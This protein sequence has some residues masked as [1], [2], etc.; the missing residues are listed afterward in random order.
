MERQDELQEEINQL[1]NRL[2]TEHP[3]LYRFIIES[4]ATI[5]NN[6]DKNSH[7]FVKSLEKYR[8]QLIEILKTTK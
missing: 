8:N 6:Q 1:T 7:D 4:P 3:A 5:P 2:R